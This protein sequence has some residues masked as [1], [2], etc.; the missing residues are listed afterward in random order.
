MTLIWDP[1]EREELRIA[2]IARFV[3]LTIKR[4][5]PAD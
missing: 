5:L 4:S 2:A 3:E 1:A